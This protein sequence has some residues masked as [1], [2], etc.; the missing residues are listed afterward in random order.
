MAR[1]VHNLR[2]NRDNVLSG[3]RVEHLWSCPREATWEEFMDTSKLEMEV[4]LIQAD[5]HE[6]HFAENYA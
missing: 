1:A 3:M 4:C 2:L 6:V 5:F